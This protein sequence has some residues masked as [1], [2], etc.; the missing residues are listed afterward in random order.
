MYLRIARPLALLA[1]AVAAGPAGCGAKT[2][3]AVAEQ[4]ASVGDAADDRMPSPDVTVGCISDSECDTG[5]ACAPAICDDGECRAAPPLDC[6]DGDPCTEDGCDIETGG[7][8]HRALALDED[9]DGFLGPRPGFQAGEPGACGDDCDDT[10]AAAFPGG[11]EICDGVDNDCNGIIDDGS[12]YEPDGSDAVRVSS[13]LHQVARGGLA[14][15]GRIYAATYRGRVS[16]SADSRN[17]VEGLRRDGSTAAE[18]PEQPISLTAGDAF[19]G[20][21]VWTGSLWGTAWEDRRDGNWEVYFNR[22][23][24]RGQ[25]LGPDLRL[26]DTTGFSLGASLLF[27]G[28]E[29][30]ASWQDDEQSFGQYRIHA[31]RIGID[32]TMLGDVVAVTP[33]DANYEA[34]TAARGA[35]G[36]GFAFTMSDGVVQVVGFRSASHDLSDLGEVTVVTT[37]GR[38]P[39]IA[40]NGGRYVIAWETRAPGGAPGNSVW[41]AALDEDGTIVVPERPVATSPTFVRDVGV[42]PLGDRLLLV[43]A[44]ERHG[45]FELYTKM[46]SADLEPITAEARVTNAPEDSLAPVPAFGPDGDVGVLFEDKREGRFQVYFTRLVCRAGS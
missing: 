42:L 38:F 26:S 25:K 13:D 36:L 8:I 37:A 15:D 12:R 23:D 20:P 41:A 5:D 19:T 39:T 9:G 16:Q 1:V 45:N 11:R 2:G 44:D 14:F 7:C 29:F 43:W 34:A 30:I 17:H 40:F 35:T 4:D 18:I 24:E 21:I 22:L 33:A 10:S 3:L 6:D 27:N 32:G 31:R 46:L 28:A